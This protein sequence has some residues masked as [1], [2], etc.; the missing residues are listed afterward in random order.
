MIYDAFLAAGTFILGFIVQIFPDS[1]GFPS[2]VHSA[3]TY[4]GN[5]GG[6]L[7]PVVPIT[8]LG[9]ILG[10][11]IAIEIIIFSFKT[12]KWLISHIPVIGGKG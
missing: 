7:N 12:F 3:A 5:L 10:L 4:M 9:T 2:E 1:T 8:T 11:I 6:M